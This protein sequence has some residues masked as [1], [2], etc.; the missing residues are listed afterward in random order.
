[1]LLTISRPP[2][3]DERPQSLDSS[4]GGSERYTAMDCIV[5]FLNRVLQGQSLESKLVYNFT[6]MHAM[7]YRSELF[8]CSSRVNI[9]DTTVCFAVSLLLAVYRVGLPSLVIPTTM[10]DSKFFHTSFLEVMISSKHEGVFIC[11]LSDI[12]SQII[13]DVWWV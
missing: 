9:S 3:T 1:M 12:T 10:S 7:S 5:V 2:P 11:D 4:C 8:T 13:F 6:N